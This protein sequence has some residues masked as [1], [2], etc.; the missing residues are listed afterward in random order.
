MNE[1]A[2]RRLDAIAARA[3]G[4][5]EAERRALDELYL[6]ECADA[7]EARMERES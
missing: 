5:C 4:D 6:L 7:V 2:Q 1:N 3:R